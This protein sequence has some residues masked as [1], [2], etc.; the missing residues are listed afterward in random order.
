[1]DGYV[2]RSEALRGACAAAIVFAVG[3]VYPVAECAP[4]RLALREGDPPAGCIGEREADRLAVGL[5]A[6]ARSD[7]RRRGHDAEPRCGLPPLLLALDQRRVA[8]LSHRVD[9]LADDA[10]AGA[11][12]GVAIEQHVAARAQFH[13]A[14]VQVLERGPGA[15]VRVDRDLDEV[16]PGRHPAVPVAAGE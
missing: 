12:R 11:R 8:R 16:H 2:A 14:A 6:L 1:M 7:S 5:G 15:G 9:V 10:V 4:T 3:P 13:G